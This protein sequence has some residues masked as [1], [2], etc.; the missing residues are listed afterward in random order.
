[1]KTTLKTL[2]CTAL[3]CAAASA[4]AVAPVETSTYMEFYAPPGCSGSTVGSVSLTGDSNPDV[5]IQSTT[6]TSLFDVTSGFAQVQIAT[7]TFG[8]PTSAATAFC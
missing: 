2:I 3:C 4:F 5:Y 1:M 6:F 8:N 7:D